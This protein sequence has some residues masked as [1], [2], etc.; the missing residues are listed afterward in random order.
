MDYSWLYSDIEKF[1]RKTLV[2]ADL[3]DFSLMG[4]MFASMRRLKVSF[5][6][7][8]IQHFV[9]KTVHDQ[10][11]EVSKQAGNARES[12]FYSLLAPKLHQHG[13]YL[14]QVIYASGD[15]ETGRKVIVL[16]DLSDSCLQSGY[17]FGPGSP[18]NWGK[19]LDSLIRAKGQAREGISMLYIAQQTFRNVAGIHS[20]YWMD[21]ALLEFS[22]LRGQQ[23]LLGKGEESFIQSQQLA[24]KAWEKTLLKIANNTSTVKWTP[25]LLQC[26][27]ASFSKVSWENF[28]LELQRENRPWTLVHGDF[29]PANILWYCGK[30]SA[31]V[32]HNKIEATGETESTQISNNAIGHPVVID[33]EMVG[34]G[35]GPQDIA[36]Y[37]ISHMSPEE[38]K[39]NEEFLLRD[40]YQHLVAD[41]ND[42][43]SSIN[44]CSETTTIH[45]SDVSLSVQ[46]ND[47]NTGKS[48][49]VSEV[50]V[51]S[52]VTNYSW[53][54]CWKD[55]VY[56]GAEHWIW[57]L[58]L[59]TDLCPDIMVQYFQDQLSAF[60]IDH[61]ITPDNIGM[62]RV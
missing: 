2:K 50:V 7:G 53:E 16:E 31:E 62:P 35:S 28:Q 61:H 19:D 24:S 23:W 49:N 56:D 46:L 14:P 33:F 11:I 59:L 6:D 42:T 3:L 21:K 5:N 57:M 27:D 41:N 29:H 36:Q 20:S 47:D 45:P 9:L 54:Q 58:A 1:T 43:D 32:D 12:F 17:F 26:M 22:W 38:R 40:Y 10:R 4:G 13:V 48:N 25:H 55:Y 18:L 30:A 39:K 44:C 60:L 52:R 34:L 15:M 51:R 37:L 8:S